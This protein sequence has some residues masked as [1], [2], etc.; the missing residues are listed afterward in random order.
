MR[1]PILNKVL[2]AIKFVKLLKII[3]TVNFIIKFP[4]FSTADMNSYFPLQNNFG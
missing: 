4:G 1:A 2:V 3:F